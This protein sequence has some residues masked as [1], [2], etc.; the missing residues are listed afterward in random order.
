M[1]PSFQADALRLALL[2]RHGG[3]WVDATA[4][5][6]MDLEDWAGAAFDEGRAFVGFYIGHY[7]APEGPPLVTS[8][9]LAVPGPEERVM[10]EWHDAYLK[11]WRGRT[12][13]KD[14]TDDAFF[15]GAN[16]DHVD[17]LMQDYLHVE[18][19]LLT[20][21]QRDAN[22]RQAFEGAALLQRA[23]DTAYVL[24]STMGMTWMRSSRCALVATPVGQRTPPWSSHPLFSRRA[25]YPQIPHSS[26]S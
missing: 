22:F 7:T 26:S 2:R 14:I 6:N 23:E 24:Q 5:A 15:S 11:L 13:E 10:V 19:V 16:L 20:L 12:S 3:A 25:P 21:L 18:L 8:W 17:P 4:I 1:R 9:A